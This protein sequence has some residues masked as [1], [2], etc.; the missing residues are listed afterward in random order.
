MTDVNG[1]VAAIRTGLESNLIVH[2]EKVVFQGDDEAQFTVI[3]ADVSVDD[4]PVSATANED[5][6]ETAAEHAGDDENAAD[7]PQVHPILFAQVN[8]G[9]PGAVCI[10]VHEGRLLLARHWRIATDSFEWE[11]PRSMGAPGEVSG[12]T[13]ERELASEAGVKATSRRLLQMMHADTCKL[14]DSIAV[15]ELDVDSESLDEAGVLADGSLAGLDDL[16]GATLAWLTP[17]EIDTMIAEGNIMDGITLAS[18]LIWKT[19][20][21]VEAEEE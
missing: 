11:F 3:Q 14:R 9:Q 2:D 1:T 6:P 5:A 8:G 12:T 4:T 16:D 17:E 15:V 10:A 20:R 21:E 7:A 18:Y 19:R 13:A